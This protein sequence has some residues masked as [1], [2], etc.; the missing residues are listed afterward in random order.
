MK[1][2]WYFY[3]PRLNYQNDLLQKKKK[4]PKIILRVP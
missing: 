2:S 1:V 4:K 3:T